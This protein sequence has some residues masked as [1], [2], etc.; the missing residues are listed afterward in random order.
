MRIEWG[1]DGVSTD[2][3]MGEGCIVAD[4]PSPQGLLV[5]AWLA[6]RNA[7]DL[8]IIV[9]YVVHFGE[10][11]ASEKMEQKKKAKIE[12][13]LMICLSS[14]PTTTTANLFSSVLGKGLSVMAIYVPAGHIFL[15]T[16]LNP[17]WL[18]G[19]WKRLRRSINWLTSTHEH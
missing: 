14:P 17:W 3:L 13:K 19:N 12:E 7:M 18:R 1:K 10:L 4:R 5:V 15:A 2:G 9:L 11:V 6:C 8:F 16:L